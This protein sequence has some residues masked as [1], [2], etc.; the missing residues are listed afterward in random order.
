M[1]T[2]MMIMTKV[3]A[4]YLQNMDSGGGASLGGGGMA[5]TM[6]GGSTLSMAST[7]TPQSM[8]QFEAHT[9]HAGR[10][11][12]GAASS[13]IAAGSADW[14]VPHGSPGATGS[15]SMGSSGRLRPLTR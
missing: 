9:P 1:M 4:R 14:S 3:V 7:T 12:G 5:A 8:M 10:A 11:S 13:G 15:S 2:T 6:G